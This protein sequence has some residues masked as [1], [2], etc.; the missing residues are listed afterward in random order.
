MWA[1]RDTDMI[2]GGEED[3]DDAADEDIP[4]RTSIRV[5]Q[6]AHTRQGAARLGPRRTDREREGVTPLAELPRSSD[7]D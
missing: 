2:V 1:E 4:T 6:R 5:D 3:D 7:Y